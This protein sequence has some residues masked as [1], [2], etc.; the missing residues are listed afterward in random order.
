VALRLP[1]LG[2]LGD[3]LA[4]QAAVYR[5]APEAGAR[6]LWSY[7]EDR[8]AATAVWQGLT[9]PLSGYHAITLAA[10]E[11]LAARPTESLLDEFFPDVPR[12]TPMPGRA[13]PWD[14]SDAARL[15]DFHPV[16]LYH[17]E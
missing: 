13:V 16:H 15:L 4:T 8:D 1:F 11:T 7:L 5:D 12:R 9:A 14:I 6:S 17:R 3:R 10:P 2:G